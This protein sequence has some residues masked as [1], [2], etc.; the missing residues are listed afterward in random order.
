MAIKFYTSK[1]S[2]KDLSRKSIDLQ[3]DSVKSITGHFSSTSY[4]QFL[5]TAPKDKRSDI[6]DAVDFVDKYDEVISKLLSDMADDATQYSFQTKSPI[7]ISSDDDKLE[8]EL[9]ELIDTLDLK[10]KCTPIVRDI[11]KYGDKF[12]RL[13]IDPEL[14]VKSILINR[15]PKSVARLENKGEL[16]G[17][18]VSGDSTPVEQYEMIHFKSLEE[19]VE[20]DILKEN[21]RELFERYFLDDAPSY[22]KSYIFKSISVSKRLKYAEDA[23]LL[24]RISKS[25]TYRNHFVE[26]G[27]G[28]VKDKV[29]IMK[30]YIRNWKKNSSKDIVNSTMTSEDNFFSYEEDIFHPVSEGK[31]SSNIDQIG[32][33]LDVAHIEDIEYLSRKRNRV[34]GT[35]NDEDQTTNRLQEDTKYAKKV[36]SYQKYLLRGLYELIDIHLDILG[37]YNKDRKYTI[38]LVEVDSYLETERNEMLS[39]AADFVDQIISL[40]NSA[41]GE[42][43]EGAEVRLQVDKEYLI[44]YL[45]SNYLR[46]PDIDYDKLFTTVKVETEPVPDADEEIPVPENG[47]SSETPEKT[48]GEDIPVRSE[49]IIES[50]RK[51]SSGVRYEKKKFEKPNDEEE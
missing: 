35:P 2:S 47:Q 42:D 30:E 45:F 9:N 26:V 12:G 41:V 29:K 36:S 16:C 19:Y 25:K 1:L 32:G 49:S 3:D 28:G 8:T 51:R 40:V 44:K 13:V 50:E 34:I 7:W 18:M 6:Y 37:K 38:N 39:S 33:D 43:E 22:G 48:T 11:I 46:L 20:D 27:T 24:G 31:G 10:V 15:H 21:H 17:F 23:L 4:S 14:G 5:E